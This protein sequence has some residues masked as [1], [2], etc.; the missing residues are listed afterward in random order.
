LF[1]K[2]TVTTMDNNVCQS[3][4]RI[5]DSFFIDYTETEIKKIAP[6]EMAHLEEVI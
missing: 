3:L 5:V 1:L 6:E 2:E 4:M